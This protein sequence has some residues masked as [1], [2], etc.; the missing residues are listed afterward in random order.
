M[1][2]SMSFLINPRKIHLLFVQYP[3]KIHILT[4]TNICS[5]LRVAQNGRFVMNPIY[6]GGGNMVAKILNFRLSES[7]KMR[8]PGPFALQNY[9]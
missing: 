2:F 7:L 1:I 6:L 4:P 5:N 9:P 8:C 3:W